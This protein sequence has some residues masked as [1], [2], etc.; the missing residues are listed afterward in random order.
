M[1]Q[2]QIQVKFVA[3]DLEK[4]RHVASKMHLNN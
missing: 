4:E 2:K 3:T 1:S